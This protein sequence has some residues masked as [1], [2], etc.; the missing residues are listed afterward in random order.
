M[1]NFQRHTQKYKIVYTEIS[2]VHTEMEN[3]PL[4]LK[5]LSLIA[6]QR[7][8]R[9]RGARG[10]IRFFQVGYIVLSQRRVGVRVIVFNVVSLNP[11]QSRCTRYNIML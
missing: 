5:G 8:I 3:A 2:E 4:L 7:L 1:K 10:V 9:A 11:A 6:W